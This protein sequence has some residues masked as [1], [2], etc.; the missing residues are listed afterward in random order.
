MLVVQSQWF[1]CSSPSC[2]FPREK[3]EVIRCPSAYCATSS[4]MVMVS[5]R[6][7]TQPALRSL[8]RTSDQSSITF[9]TTGSGAFSTAVSFGPG[10]SSA[11]RVF[12]NASQF[13]GSFGAG[14]LGGGG[15]VRTFFDLSYFY[16]LVRTDGFE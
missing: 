13:S 3:Y 12:D 7:S 1:F 16:F 10:S 14:P 15:I 9:G 11:V 8:V 2:T 5:M 4:G 6:V